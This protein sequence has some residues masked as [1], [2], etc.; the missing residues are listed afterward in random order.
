MKLEV[1]RFNS[2]DDFTT[3]LLFDVTDNHRSFLCYT[4]EDEARTVKQWG[5][6]R[7]PAGKYKLTLRNEGGFHTR[8]LAKF[9]AEF[10]KGMIYVNEVPNFEY[11]LWHIGNDDDDTAGCLLV[12]KTSQDNFIGNSTTAYKEIY[13]PIRD[14]IL[15]GEEVTVTYIDYDGTI[16]SN[17]AKDHVVNISQVSKNQ[18]DI[19]DILSTEIKHLKAEVKALRQA[20]ILKGMQV[21]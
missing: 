5:E 16:V 21:K 3:G 7:I 15:S 8:Y 18:E 20:I 6:T 1:L 10:H 4:L 12:G 2:S 17:K 13:P 11:I 19:M 14:A 9:G